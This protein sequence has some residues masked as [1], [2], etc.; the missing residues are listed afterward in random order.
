[1]GV[2]NIDDFQR[3]MKAEMERNKYKNSIPNYLLE[4]G[5]WRNLKSYLQGIEREKSLI[6]M[7]NYCAVL[8]NGIRGMPK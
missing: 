4:N 5:I 3:A 1:M 8:W 6:D 7:A 2:P